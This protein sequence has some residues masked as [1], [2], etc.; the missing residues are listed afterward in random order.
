MIINR[1]GIGLVAGMAAAVVLSAGALIAS[2]GPASAAVT[3]NQAAPDFTLTNSYGEEVSLS[4]FA[5]QRVV[6]E[7]T[8]HGCPFVKKHYAT[9][10]ANMQSLQA[11]AGE[12]EYVWLTI[13]SSAEGK[14]GYV[15]GEEANALTDNRDAAPVHVLLDPTGEV[16][17]LYDAK[18]TPHMYVIDEDGI[19]VYQGAID[20]NPSSNVEDIA[21]ATNYVASTF[22][23][24]DA[25]EAP[26]PAVTKAYGC[27]V[28]YAD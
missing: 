10:P 6:L 5:G 12:D 3:N 2:T 19:L 22:A 28:K 23:A 1:R 17:R 8:N 27:S 14:Q 25:G 15:T 9:P 21:T 13:I 18:T 26:D 20:D 4:D 24:L 11:G 16:G 7:W